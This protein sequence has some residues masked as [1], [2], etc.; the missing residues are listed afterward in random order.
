MPAQSGVLRF[1]SFEADLGASE[2]RRN[3]IRLK[4]QS[5]PFRVLAL[6]L[7]RP[8]QVLTREELSKNSGH[9]APS[10]ITSKDWRP[11]STRRV[12]RWATPRPTRGSLKRFRGV[13]TGSSLLLLRCSANLQ[14]SLWRFVR[15][16]GA[17][18]SG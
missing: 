16:E 8:G 2:L 4:L 10:S 17:D 15:R 6:L 14:A 7:Q 13:V 12:M 11:R 18:A 9:R 5:Q 1:G 3:G